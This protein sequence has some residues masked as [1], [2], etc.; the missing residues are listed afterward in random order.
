MNYS[1]MFRNSEVTMIGLIAAMILVPSIGFSQ[2]QDWRTAVVLPKI[3]VQGLPPAKRNV[4][5][6]LL[7]K[8][9]CPCGRD[10]KI[11]Q[12][13]LDDP[14]C[15]KCPRIARRIMG[16]ARASTNEAEA[17]LWCNLVQLADLCRN[18]FE[19]E[20]RLRPA[21]DGNRTLSF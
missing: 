9:D 3:N 19:S 2:N 15:P 10:M 17:M 7:R 1:Q 18:Y 8:S 6:Q 14:T 12:C 4:A 16:V 5:L 11:A 20:F 21:R 13:L